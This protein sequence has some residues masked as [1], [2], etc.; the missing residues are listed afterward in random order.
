MTTHA[1]HLGQRAA[2]LLAWHGGAEIHEGLTPRE[3]DEIEARFDFEFAADHRIFLGNGLPVGVQWPNW[4]DL[5]GD[6]R[7]RLDRPIRGVMFDVEYN[8]FW[9]PGWGPRPL[10]PIDA[11]AAA[12]AHLDV[13]PR[14]VPVYAHRYIPAGRGTHS[15]PVLSVRQTDVIPYGSDLAD[16]VIREFC[17]APALPNADG[18]PVPFWSDLVTP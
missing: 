9:H 18:Q 12:A 3:L 11:G 4:R 8:D 6:L 16:Y 2:E 14:L 17:G 10:D 1:K 13:V 7:D 15:N 5:S